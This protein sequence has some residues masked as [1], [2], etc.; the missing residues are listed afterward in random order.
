MNEHMKVYVNA[1]YNFLLL[2]WAVSQPWSHG[3]EDLF[4]MTKINPLSCRWMLTMSQQPQGPRTQNPGLKRLRKLCFGCC[5]FLFVFIFLLFCIAVDFIFNSL[6]SIFHLKECYLLETIYLQFVTLIY[7]IEGLFFWEINV[8]MLMKLWVKSLWW[9]VLM[10]LFLSNL[11]TSMSS[12]PDF[13]KGPKNERNS[14]GTEHSDFC[15]R[16]F[17]PISCGSQQLNLHS[18]VLPSTSH[19]YTRKLFSIRLY[20]L[21]SVCMLRES[22]NLIII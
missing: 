21:L 8:C 18:T 19:T 14:C 2:L 11:D 22:K 13:R 3:C 9:N 7:W 5:L 16:A 4:I 20:W 6:N 12:L 15:M 10:K 1:N 17:V